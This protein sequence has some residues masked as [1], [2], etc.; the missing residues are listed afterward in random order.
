MLIRYCREY[1]D[2]II[3][4]KSLIGNKL[5]K[6][7]HVVLRSHS[8]IYIFCLYPFCYMLSRLGL[9]PRKE[10]DIKRTSSGLKMY[11]RDV[12]HLTAKEEKRFLI[13]V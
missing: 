8:Q 9:D 7:T 10:C 13:E 5:C 12:R 4:P 1:D 3:L 6:Y 11:S 2:A